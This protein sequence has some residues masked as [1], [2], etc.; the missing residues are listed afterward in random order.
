[1][2]LVV[3]ILVCVAA[4]AAAP[5][6]AGWTWPVG[7]PVLR[8]FTFGDDPYAGGV[9]R[10][11]DI[12]AAAGE[13]VRAPAAGRVAFTGTVPRSGRTV[14][15]E[16][17]DGYSVTLVHLAGYSVRSGE[18]VAEGAVVGNAGASGDAEWP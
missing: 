10:G 11:A 13:G 1:M 6:A 15:I 7:G 2:R 4:L 18:T 17:A 16:T 8:P 3:T 5:A 12:G 9:H 14:T